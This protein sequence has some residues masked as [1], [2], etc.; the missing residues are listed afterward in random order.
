MREFPHYKF[1][2]QIYKQ[3]KAELRNYNAKNTKSKKNNCNK[4][5]K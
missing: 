4:N 2:Q 5:Y 3:K 1:K